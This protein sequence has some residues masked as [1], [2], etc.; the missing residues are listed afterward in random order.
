M[1]RV[2]LIFATALVALMAGALFYA[3]RIPTTVTPPPAPE[4]ATPAPRQLEAVTHPAFTLPDLEGNPREF[5]EWDGKH[6]LINFW[7]TWCAPCRREIPLLKAFQE[8]HG[9]EGFQVLGIAVDYPDQVASYAQTAEFNYPI[10]VGQQE[11]MAV[12]ESSG[13]E[14]YGMPFTMF[15]AADGELVGAYMGE[16]H[17]SHLDAIVNIL[18]RLEQGEISKDEARGAIELL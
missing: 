11:A 17:Q 18:S 12:A 4:Q 6:R 16:L 9:P 5:A 13:V 1:S 15:V 7:A 8:A 2:M 10:L 3:A 14:F